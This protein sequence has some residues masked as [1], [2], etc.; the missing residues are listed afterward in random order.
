MIAKDSLSIVI[1]TYKGSETVIRLI[2]ELYSVFDFEEFEIIL[3]NDDSPDITETLIYKNLKKFKKFKY[4][5]LQN[6]LGED[7]ATNIGINYAIYKYIMVMDDD[8]QHTPTECSKL[9]NK[10]KNFNFDVVYSNYKV[11]NHSKIRNFFSKVFNYIYLFNTKNKINYISSFKVFKKSIAD[12]F[13]L[14]GNFNKIFIDQYILQNNLVIESFD[15]D[16]RKRM[17]SSSYTLIK[18]LKTFLIKIVNR[19]KI[20]SN[21]SKYLI[22]FFCLFLIFKIFEIIYSYLFLKN[23]YP[24]G[25]PTI[26]ILLIVN[27][28]FNYV[29]FFKFLDNKKSLNITKYLEINYT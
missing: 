3:V 9:Y 7:A 26:A 25:Y 24:Q 22:S 21:I 4:I 20:I 15:L 27:L 16:H 6:N 29:I 13:L 28:I 5:R 8:Y 23:V 2:L 1:P 10:I 14:N 18:L 19:H 17:G 11:K 12:Q